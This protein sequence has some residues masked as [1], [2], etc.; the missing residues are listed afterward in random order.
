MLDAHDR[1]AGDITLSDG[2]RLSE[3][4]DR[5]RR[6]VSL[7]VHQDPEIF[8]IEM[9]KIFARSWIP[10]AHESEIPEPGDYVRRY[11]G[12]DSC[13]VVRTAEGDINVL[14]N[15]CTHRG[16]PLCREEKGRSRT[17]TC[18][19][20]GWVFDRDGTVRGAPHEREMYDD[21]LRRCADELSL[22]TARTAINGGFVFANWDP[23]AEPFDDYLGDCKWYLDAMINR[24]DRGFEVVGAPQRHIIKANWKLLAEQLPDGYHTSTLHRSFSQLGVFEHRVSSGINVAT[25]G[26]HVMRLVNFKATWGLGNGGDD[27]PLMDRLAAV[28][29]PGTDA[30][31]TAQ[32]PNNLSEGQMRLLSETPPTVMGLFPGTDLFAFWSHDGTEAGGLGPVIMVHAWIPK[33][34]GLFEMVNWILVEKDASPELRELTRRTTIRS[35]GISGLIEQDDAEAWRGVQRSTEGVMGRRMRGKYG[36]ELGIN[37][38]DGFEGGGDVF[39][40]TARD[41]AQW[42]W[43]SRYF[44]VMTS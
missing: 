8:E 39:A 23:L 37:R 30:E 19:Y 34:P 5:D 17:F 14:L 3:L 44:D 6:E 9:E 27:T 15:V 4:V 40:G 36:A 18:P 10:V 29:P 7:R 41:D 11:I 42:A 38:P 24:T 21:W 20:H 32:F 28:P 1:L 22:T 43:W 33:A 16:M 25:S 13:L 35:F 2:T 31:M 12:Q 26:G